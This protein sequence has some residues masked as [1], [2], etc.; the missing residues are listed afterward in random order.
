M[1]VLVIHCEPPG[2]LGGIFSII[3]PGTP[4]AEEWTKKMCD[5]ESESSHVDPSLIW[6]WA[7]TYLATFEAT[8]ARCFV[9]TWV[10]REVVLQGKVCSPRH[11]SPA[12]RLQHPMIWGEL[13]RLSVRR[14]PRLI[15]L[16][17]RM[18]T[19]DRQPTHRR[20]SQ[21]PITR[22]AQPK[23]TLRKNVQRMRVHA[24]DLAGGE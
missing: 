23:P 3:A 14:L 20:E 16:R 1:L 4:S 17:T 8:A 21:L 22:T 11:Y 12:L 5:K 13:R 18:D 19:S 15:P 7:R 2:V 24:E 6:E 9:S 10:L